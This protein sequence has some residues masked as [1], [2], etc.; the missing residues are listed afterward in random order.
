V[1]LDGELPSDRFHAGQ[2]VGDGSTGKEKTC[3]KLFDD[4]AILS[5]RNPSAT[6]EL[7]MLSTP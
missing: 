6:A 1:G 2:V 4:R 5:L 3:R 7:D